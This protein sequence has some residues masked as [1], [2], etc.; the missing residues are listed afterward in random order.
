MVGSLIPSSRFVVDRVLAKI[1]WKRGMVIVEYGPGV[2]TITEQILAR[3]SPEAKLVVLET[4][5]DFV[6]HLR[7]TFK[8]PRLQ[9]AH[10]SAE[11]VRETLEASGLGG[12]DYIV[13]GVPYTNMPAQLCHRMIKESRSALNPEG[14]ILIYQF[15]RVV[16]PHLYAYFDKVYQDFEVRNLLPIRLFYCSSEI[17]YEV[18]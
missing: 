17:A 4:H 2:G 15:R 18:P 12:A 14:T 6:S 9:V 8:D 7:R 5:Y 11:N 1:D 10:T 13:S 16:L 3:M